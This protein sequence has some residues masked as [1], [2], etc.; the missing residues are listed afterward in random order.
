MID[1][2]VKAAIKK[3]GVVYS[4]DRPGRHRQVFDIMPDTLNAEQ[5]F[6]TSSGAFVDR[7]EAGKIAV[8]SGQIKW[9]KWPPQLFTEDL[10]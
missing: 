3:N 4:V 8:A 1:S 10:W 2:I 9:L 7:V 5:G 6:L